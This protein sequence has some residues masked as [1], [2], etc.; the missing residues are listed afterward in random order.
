MCRPYIRQ[1][2]GHMKYYKYDDIYN[3]IVEN[4][5][6][7]LETEDGYTFRQITVN[8][9]EYMAS[10]ILYPEWGMFLAEGQIDYDTIEEVINISKE[11]FEQ[12]WNSYLD[13]RINNWQKT[14]SEYPINKSIQGIIQIFYPQG[15]IVRADNNVLGLADFAETF[16]S[17]PGLIPSTKVK[18]TATV[19]GYDE[20]NHWLILE[21]PQ[22]ITS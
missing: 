21:K 12:V 15:V 20:T 19:S 13:K 1:E 16:A 18:I 10:N 17:A 4:G 6:T 5:V 8:D 22:I 2:R 7:Y 11:E 9:N 14:K 3:D